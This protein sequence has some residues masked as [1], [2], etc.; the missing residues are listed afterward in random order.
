MGFEYIWPGNQT[1]GGHS[2]IAVGTVANTCVFISA[3][4]SLIAGNAEGSYSPTGAVY[5]LN[6][7]DGLMYDAND[8]IIGPSYGNANSAN[9]GNYLGQMGDQLITAGTCARVIHIPVAIS[10]TSVNDWATGQM[11]HRL[12][13]AHELL[14]ALGWDN[15]ANVTNVAILWDQGQTDAGN[16]MSQVTYRTTWNTMKTTISV[17]GNTVWR[18]AKSTYWYQAYTASASTYTPIQNAQS[19][20]AP[21]GVVTGTDVLAGPDLDTITN[22][23]GTGTC[24]YDG[25]HWKAIGATQAGCLWAKNINAGITCTAPC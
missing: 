23:S 21:N 18:V 7:Y 8:I 13:R 15:T 3:G 12:V 20:A 16:G 11:L 2:A 19:L 1:T 14:K 5:V 22:S 25:L 10:S 17:T 6:P 4:Q 24:R 9:T